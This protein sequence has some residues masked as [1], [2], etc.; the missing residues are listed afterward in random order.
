LS[1]FSPDNRVLDKIVNKLEDTE[2]DDVEDINGR[3]SQHP[4]YRRMY[5]LLLLP[6]RD[7]VDDGNLY[8]GDINILRKS[9]YFKGSR[10]RENLLK[11]ATMC[12]ESDVQSFVFH[13]EDI[14]VFLD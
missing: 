13:I 9:L 14:T 10:Q 2:L 5:R 7:L 11:M 4:L 8:K 3:D 6:T 1:L 12:R